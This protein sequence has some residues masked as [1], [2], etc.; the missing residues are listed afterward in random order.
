MCK[1]YERNRIPINKLLLYYF[2][3]LMP[4]F[5]CLFRNYESGDI[6]A[7]LFSAASLFQSND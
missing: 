6:S 2:T 1:P 5:V 7:A 3:I 4:E